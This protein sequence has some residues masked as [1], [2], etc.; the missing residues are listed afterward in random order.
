MKH[1]NN[2]YIQLGRDVFNEYDYQE[3]PM[4]SRWIFT[5]LNE[6]E[7]KYTGKNEDFFFRS[8]QLLAQDC[9]ISEATLKRYKAPLVKYGYIKTW[10]MHFVNKDG[11]MSEKKVC[12][13]RILK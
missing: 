13:Y 12:A 6:L 7:H 8:N 4:Y 2:C 11:K 9:G 10:S 3:L 1:G 5:V